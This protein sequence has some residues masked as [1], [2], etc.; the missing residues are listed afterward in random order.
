MNNKYYILIKRVIFLMLII[1]L[2]SLTIKVNAKTETLKVLG[3]EIKYAD[4][5]SVY[6]NTEY[7]VKDTEFRAVWV[8]PLTND[9]TGFSSES[10]Y[11]RQIIEVLENMEIYNLN[12]MLFHVRIMNDALYES[13]YNSWSRYYHTNPSWDALPW[14]IEECHKRGIEFHA[15]MN[16]Y[17]VTTDVSKSLEDIAKDYKSANAAH[18]P[19]NL[20]KGT[21]CV[22]LDPAVP[23]VRSFLV[24]T[25]M[26][27]VENY[28]VDAIHFDDYFYTAGID[29][30]KSYSLYNSKGLSRADFRRDQIDMFIESLAKSLDMYNKQNNRRV[31]LGI[32]PTGVYRNGSGVVTYENGEPVSNGSAT[33]GYAHYDSPLYADTIKWIK[34]EWIDY[35]LPQSYHAITNS[36]AP[37]CDLVSWW[38]KMLKGSNVN[39][40]ASIGLY[41]SSGTGN[42]SWSTNNMEAYQQAL[43]CNT[44]ENVKGNSIYNYIAYVGNKGSSST[45]SPLKSAWSLPKILP[46]IKTSNPINISKVNNLVLSKTAK[47]ISVSFDKLDDAKFYV[48][49]RSKTPITFSADEVLDVVGNITNGNKIEYVDI[50][51]LDEGYYYGVRAQSYSLTL[52]DGVS[53]QAKNL[54]ESEIISLGEITNF[55]TTDNLMPG[56]KITVFWEDLFYP[57]GEE[58]KYTL[59]YTFDDV[60]YTNITDYYLSKNKNNVDIT[61]PTNAEKIK[62]ILKAEND[63]G[64]STAS[65]EKEINKSVDKLVGFG[66]YG[67]PYSEKDL[68][69]YWLGIKRSNVIYEIQVS[70]DGYTWNTLKEVNTTQEIYRE[71]IKPLVGTNLYRIKA[72]INE[73]ITFSQTIIINANSYLADIKNI[74][75][76]GESLKDYYLIKEENSFELTWTSYSS[77]SICSVMVSNDLKNWYMLKV[78]SQ[79]S[80]VTKNGTKYKANI[81]CSYMYGSFY[82]KIL[83]NY[84]NKKTESELIKVY[85]Q[86]EYVFYDEISYYLDNEKNVFLNKMNIFMND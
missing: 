31:Q 73:S 25:C 57:L 61:I 7:M 45:L 28:D 17:R 82:V 4:G 21:K 39:L 20:L 51:Q 34:N 52:G 3:D 84:N 80:I 65:L 69:I 71:Y 54:E 37:Y 50:T 77:E 46:E 33:R 24:S 41:M 74:K 30:S 15:W 81:V 22:I 70:S 2:L 32:S 85:V 64:L 76:D 49:Y 48:I 26:E 12:V 36:A 56:E 16:P 29:D 63:V 67:E 83:E 59:S 5:T 35:I 53:A 13:K 72:R 42:A 47:G 14:I 10:Q 19:G 27:L 79:D 6:I 11:K 55:D 9:I 44:L 43:F 75:I 40:Y 38:N 78:Y 18:N 86:K 8:S 66:Y 23:D 58:I 60:E 62:I 68:L 1:L